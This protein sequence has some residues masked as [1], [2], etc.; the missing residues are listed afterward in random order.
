[1]IHL[2]LDRELRPY[3]SYIQDI[4][5]ELQVSD[6]KADVLFTYGDLE[7]DNLDG[8]CVG[9]SDFIEVYISNELAQDEMLKT[10]AHELVHVKQKVMKENHCEIEA[11][12]LEQSLYESFWSEK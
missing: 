6:K 2:F 11:Y 3:V 8:Y 7:E 10:L 12:D 4:L 5:D 1:M 9:D